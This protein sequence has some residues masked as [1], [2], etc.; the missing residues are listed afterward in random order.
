[1]KFKNQ[2]KKLKACRES[3]EWVG[4]KTIEQ[5]WE[6]CENSQWMIWILNQT[7]LD[8]IDPICDIAERVFYLVPENNRSVCSNA[9]NAARRRANK[10]ELEAAFDAACSASAYASDAEAYAYHPASFAASFTAAY[11]YAA[12]YAN[13]ASAYNAAASAAN[14]AYVVHYVARAAS[15]V[16]PNAAAAYIEEKKKQCDI[17]RKYFTI[18]QVK[19]AF[20]KIVA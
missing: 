14:A 2:L 12:V 4:D 11:A 19:E 13:T 16:S 9:I 8:L 20:S 17:F 5:A 1:M 3:L 10:D 15:D 6:T 7:D 18:D